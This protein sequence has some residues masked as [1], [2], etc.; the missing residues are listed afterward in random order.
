[1]DNRW[2]ARAL[3][4]ALCALPAKQAAG[5]DTTAQPRERRPS[6]LGQNFPNPFNP[7]THIPFSVNGCGGIRTQ[8]VVTL[9]IYNVLAQLVAIPYLEGTI[10]PDPQLQRLL[11]PCGDYTAFWDGNMIRTGRKAPSGVYLIELSLDGERPQQRKAFVA[12]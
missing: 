5:Q 1:M 12:K 3:V 11:L 2:A 10:G 4:L 6:V 7:A 8:R 9:R